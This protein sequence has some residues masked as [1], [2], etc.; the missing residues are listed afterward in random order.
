MGQVGYLRL[1]GRTSR[2]V[3]EATYQQQHGLL[4]FPGATEAKHD[5]L[6]LLGGTPQRPIRSR[7]LVVFKSSHNLTDCPLV[8]IETENRNLCCGFE[9][10][11]RE[12]SE[13]TVGL[14]PCTGFTSSLVAI[15]GKGEPDS[16]T[17]S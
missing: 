13:V 6:V 2:S 1:W 3:T 7:W 4:G 15:S 8:H 16:C 5:I 12:V 10:L 9:T 17:P 11:L 14:L